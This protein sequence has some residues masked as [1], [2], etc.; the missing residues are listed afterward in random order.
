VLSY[1]CNPSRGSSPVTRFGSG[2]RRG[3]PSGT[4]KVLR[5]LL[6]CRIRRRPNPHICRWGLLGFGAVAP[7]GP[8]LAVSGQSRRFFAALVSRPAS[9]PARL[10]TSCL[11]SLLGLGRRQPQPW[12]VWGEANRRSATVCPLGCTGSIGGSA[13]P[14]SRSLVRWPVGR[15]AAS[16]PVTAAVVAVVPQG[17]SRCPSGVLVAVCS[18]SR[19]CGGR[20]PGG[21]RP[22]RPSRRR[23]DK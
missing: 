1:G 20:L 4:A 8:Q 10:Q 14:A 16:W 12:W 19:G 6:R 9:T 5:S 15:R 13:A 11:A 21:A 17:G 22:R 3:H 23:V 18:R 7:T 2:L